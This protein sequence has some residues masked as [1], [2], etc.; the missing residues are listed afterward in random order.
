MSVIGPAVL[1][2][3][4]HA[5][6][7]R[8]PKLVTPVLPSLRTI[9]HACLFCFLL[10]VAVPSLA[11]THTGPDKVELKVGGVSAEQEQNI[12]AYVEGLALM[13]PDLA[14]PRAVQEMVSNAAARALKALGYY[15]PVISVETDAQAHRIT[16]HVQPGEPVR[17]KRVTLRILG[18][19]AE[20]EA[21]RQVIREHAPREGEPLHHG[22]YED[23]KTRLQAAAQRRGYFDARFLK[24][25][26]QV[27]PD[28]RQAT[29]DVE[30]DSGSRY[31]FGEVLFSQSRLSPDRL[32]RFVRFA[33]GTGYDEALIADLNSRLL[34]SGYFRSVTVQPDRS[35]MTD[36]TLPVQ[37]NL[38]D[39]PA[40][41]VS[42]GLGY[43]TDSGPRLSLDWNKPVLNP[44]GHSLDTQFNLARNKQEVTLSWKIP[45]TTPNQDY[46]LLQ[47]GWVNDIFDVNEL[48]T[49]TVTINRQTHLPSGWVRSLFTRIRSE[50]GVIDNAGERQVVEDDFYLSPGL[51]FTRSVSDSRL[52]PTR[53]HFL[54]FDLEFSHP[55]LQ[56]DTQYLRLHG[57]AKWL[58]PLAERHQL[59]LRTELGVLLKDDF[60]EVPVSAR[61]F[62]GGDQ[63]IRGYD[64]NTL[65]P[66]DSSGDK[67]GGDYLAVAS[68]EYL[69]RVLDNWQ[70]A[71]FADHGG[72]FSEPFTPRHTGVGTGI[73]WLS[74]VGVFR[75]D[76]ARA[77][78]TGKFR[79]H[80]VMGTVL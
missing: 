65:S 1:E 19:A 46:W 33:P 42:I 70:L 80:L 9:C 36:H 77:L 68:A 52:R 24:R 71:L 66:E 2:S 43:G 35:Q 45:V 58:I 29:L 34:N 13:P 48:S 75:L 64:Y 38:E 56:S 21:I 30:W 47:A 14:R 50:R 53:G 41:E 72:A 32:A 7:R 49:T 67:P 73:R 8:F 3:A 37:V 17:W 55:A 69:Y 16:L 57:L 39:R 12:R 54:S 61:F 27:D 10:V 4:A 22:R 40:N 44:A 51:S 15:S 5:I 25:L 63:S 74:P 31:H 6:S 11:S 59:L 79:L 60:T 23:F 28:S 62:T 78:D 26:V 20:D 76:V 18:D